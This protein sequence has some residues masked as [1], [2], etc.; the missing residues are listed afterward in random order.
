MT[1]VTAYLCRQSVEVSAAVVTEAA[2]LWMIGAMRFFVTYVD[3]EG[4]RFVVWDG[5][6]H[7]DAIMAARGWG[8]PVIDRSRAN[9]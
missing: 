6:T 5:P 4:D 8:V 3:E 7:A 1:D 2:E 9:G